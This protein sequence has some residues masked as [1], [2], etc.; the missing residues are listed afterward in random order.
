MGG[1]HFSEFL[2][3]MMS[4]ALFVDIQLT[5][6]LFGD[7]RGV[8]YSHSAFAVIPKACAQQRPIHQKAHMWYLQSSTL[9][10]P[11]AAQRFS[12]VEEAQQKLEGIIT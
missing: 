4:M 11:M 8:L 2:L 3:Q 5:N 9:R 12:S 6:V 1:T 10:L 7:L